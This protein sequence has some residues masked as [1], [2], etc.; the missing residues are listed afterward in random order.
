MSDTAV[1]VCSDCGLASLRGA[2]FAAVEHLCTRPRA[3]AAAFRGLEAR[4]V[5]LAVCEQRDYEEH[6]TALRAAGVDPFGVERVVIGSRPPDE[7]RRLIRAAVAKL[8][9]LPA[10]ETGKPSAVRGAL[11]RRA[12]FSLASIVAESPVAVIDEAACLGSRRCGLCASACP[13]PAIQGSLGVPTVDATTCTACGACVPG[14]PTAAL[15]LAGSS[16]AQIEAQLGELVPGVDGIVFACASARTTAPPGWA[17]I[18]LPTLALLTPG[19]VLQVRARGAEVKLEPC[20]G[21]CCAGASQVAALAARFAGMP[22]PEQLAEPPITLREPHATADGVTRLAAMTATDVVQSGASPLGM[23]AFDDTRCTLCSACAS[24]CPTR[25]LRFEE[26]AAANALIHD[27]AACVA[28]GRC[29]EICPEQAIG[30]RR[31][32]D[33]ERLRRGATELL[34]AGRERCGVCGTELPPRPLRRRVNELLG[35]PEAPLGLCSL[36]AASLPRA[37]DTMP[38]T[39]R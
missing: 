26:T 25:A 39:R 7:A 16:V 31:G 21:P 5:V 12:L 9:A 36:C 4:R 24:A 22:P 32:I 27:P 37:A 19:W 33:V 28:C 2:R 3:A 14:C 15:R 11:S 29:A 1:L 30:V 6:L 13:E 10:G 18:E 17:L 20:G 38:P 35:Q 8:D 23:L 34:R